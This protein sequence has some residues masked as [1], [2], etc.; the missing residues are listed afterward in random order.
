LCCL[1]AILATTTTPGVR[2]LAGISSLH[3]LQLP[4]AMKIGAWSMHELAKFTALRNLNLRGCSQLQDAHML[5]LLQRLTLL[6]T[7]SLQ[8]CSGLTGSFLPDVCSRLVNLQALN[9]A[10][11]PGLYP[12]QLSCLSAL[13]A[14]QQLDVTGGSAVSGVEALLLLGKLQHLTQLHGGHWRCKGSVAS[15]ASFLDISSSSAAADGGVPDAEQ[16]QQQQQ[17]YPLLPAQLQQL[18][19]SHLSCSESFLQVLLLSLPSS[20]TALDLSSCS[21]PGF[22]RGSNCLQGLQECKQLRTLNLSG[23]SGRLAESA[24][25][26][27]SELSCLTELQ[28]DHIDHS[29]S[30]SSGSESAAGEASSSGMSEEDGPGSNGSGSSSSRASS[31]SCSQGISSQSSSSDGSCDSRGVH[32][33][34]ALLVGSDVVGSPT[35]G[36]LAA[37]SSSGRGIGGALMPVRRSLFAEAA[38]ARAAAIADFLQY[39][40][41]AAEEETAT[42][43]MH[44][45]DCCQLQQQLP[46]LAH[47]QQLQHLTISFSTWVDDSVL[48]GLSGLTNLRSLSIVS[49]HNFSG[50]GFS[51][52][53]SMQGLTRLN[54]SGCGGVSDAGLA[55]LA[56]ECGGLRE[57]VLAGCKAVTDAGVAEL[58]QLRWLRQ[59]NMTSN[60]SITHRWEHLCISQGLP[61]TC[62]LNACSSPIESQAAEQGCFYHGLLLPEQQCCAFQ[63]HQKV[64]D[65][66]AMPC[67]QHNCQTACLCRSMAALF[68][69]LRH[70]SHLSVDLC[71]GM[72][73]AALAGL[74][75]A[76]GLAAADLRGCWQITNEGERWLNMVDFVHS[77]TD[78]CIYSCSYSISCGHHVHMLA[79][80]AGVLHVCSCQRHMHASQYST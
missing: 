51:S 77:V 75:A 31:M 48:T 58:A 5:Q 30:S 79:V 39:R 70:L 78:A 16:Q 55:A 27:L 6:Q 62:D 21:V 20:L 22:G 63:T 71:T 52:W 11:C 54:L 37:N 68:P 42:E 10:Y 18:S 47:M 45:Q 4:N 33:V 9:L 12:G 57:L 43:Q 1:L 19:V 38:A 61:P 23:S 28:L 72:C 56:T 44:L 35:K 3:S 25:Q 7:L 40:N 17:R 34:A 76:P 80:A 64:A 46:R 14:L 8:S 59:L 65:T 2:H 24:L 49:C 41:A 74:A 13:P 67:V 69:R 53:G 36:M 60:R 73:D 50:V 32:G 26:Y 15:L 66:K 29:S